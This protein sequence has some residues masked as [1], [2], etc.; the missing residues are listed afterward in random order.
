MLKSKY[1]WI[2]A[3]YTVGSRAL[4]VFSFTFPLSLV[5]NHFLLMDNYK[6]FPFLSLSLAP[7]LWRSAHFLNRRYCFCRLHLLFIHVFCLDIS[8]CRQQVHNSHFFFSPVPMEKSKWISRRMHICDGD[9]N[10][11]KY[12]WECICAHWNLLIFQ[13]CTKIS[14]NKFQN[15][16]C[17]IGKKTHRRKETILEWNG[18]QENANNDRTLFV[19]GSN[20]SLVSLTTFST[21]SC[22]LYLRLCFVFPLAVQRSFVFHF[23]HDFNAFSTFVYDPSRNWD[24]QRNGLRFFLFYLFALRCFFPLRL[25]RLLQPMAYKFAAVLLGWEKL[26]IIPQ[27]VLFMQQI[28]AWTWFVWHLNRIFSLNRLWNKFVCI[29]HHTE[30]WMNI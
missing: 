25:S 10:S 11:N 20:H 28:F 18:E 17:K 15:T 9:G 29:P 1:I 27:E 4:L 16:H 7:S 30:K 26:W 24:K 3:I 6:Q 21:W 5:F 23:C 19:L 13:F 8:R 2:G 12:K 14:W 22:K